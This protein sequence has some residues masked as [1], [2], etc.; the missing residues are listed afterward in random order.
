[1]KP[2][3]KALFD[4]MDVLREEAIKEFEQKVAFE[5]K[6]S[7]SLW[8]AL[9]AALVFITHNSAILE[10]LTEKR[11][12]LLGIGIVLMVLYAFFLIWIQFT[13]TN[14]RARQRLWSKRMERLIIPRTRVRIKNIIDIILS[15]GARYLSPLIQFFVALSLFLLLIASVYNK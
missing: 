7:F 1:M 6:M 5:W 8:A 15:I 4:A 12:L 14:N 3:V 9:G 2:D 13:H 11:L 10:L